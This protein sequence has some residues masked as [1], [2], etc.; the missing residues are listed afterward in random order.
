MIEPTCLR[1]DR[2]GDD[3]L[4]EALAKQLS[5]RVSVSTAWHRARS[6]HRCR[7]RATPAWKSSSSLAT[8]RSSNGPDNRQSSHRSIGSSPPRMRASGRAQ[9]M[10]HLAAQASPKT[11]SHHA[12]ADCWRGDSTSSALCARPLP[13]FRPYRPPSAAHPSRHEGRGSNT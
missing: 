4:C 10:K 13:H 9:F 8:R 12:A 3:E 7:S 1:T 6:R 5:Q 11:N 2:G